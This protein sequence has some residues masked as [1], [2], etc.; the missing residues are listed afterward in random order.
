[1]E[2]GTPEKVEEKRDKNIQ[3]GLEILAKI[4]SRDVS[5]KSS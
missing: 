5:E 1:M 4:I 2:E 3:E